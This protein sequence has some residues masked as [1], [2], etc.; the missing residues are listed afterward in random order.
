MDN[1]KEMERYLSEEELVPI[2]LYVPPNV[3]QIKVIATLLTKELGFKEATM[4]MDLP[5]IIDARID[6]EEWEA[7]NIHYTF[8][9][10]LENVFQN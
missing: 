6:G 2:I 10:E 3:A 7:D 1:K 9:E 5:Q 8:M 4:D